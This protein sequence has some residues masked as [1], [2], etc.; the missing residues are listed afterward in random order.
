MFMSN[1]GVLMLSETLINGKS[2]RIEDNIGEAIHI[3]FG[4]IRLDMTIRE[5]FDFDKQITALAANMIM[6]EEKDS[7]GVSL[8]DEQLSDSDFDSNAKTRAPIKNSIN[9]RKDVEHQQFFEIKPEG[10]DDVYYQKFLKGKKYIHAAYKS[11]KLKYIRVTV[12]NGHRFESKPLSLSP[13]YIFLSGNQPYYETYCELLRASGFPLS[14][15]PQKYEKLIES[16]KKGFSKKSGIVV[17]DGHIHD[18]QHRAAWLY[19]TYG[20]EFEVE[21]FEIVL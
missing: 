8:N 21:V 12:Y 2:F 3:H 9:N 14:A 7:A 16:L 5:F 17:M 13:A 1:P 15:S 10:I 18:G 4:D 11:V 20:P 6:G 19:K